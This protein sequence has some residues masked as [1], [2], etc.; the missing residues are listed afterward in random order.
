M[1]LPNSLVHIPVLKEEILEHVPPHAKKIL[2]CTVGGGGHSEALLNRFSRAQLLA[3]D[4]DPIALEIARSRLFPYHTR[5][6]L[7]HSRFSKLE[8][9]LAEISWKFDF[10]V[11]DLGVSSLQLNHPE[12]GFSFS[13]DGPLDMRMDPNSEEKDAGQWVNQTCEQELVAIFQQYGEVRFARKIGRGIVQKRKEQKFSSTQ[14]LAAFVASLIPRRFHKK[15]IH[16][17]TQVF[18]A[19]RIAVNDELQEVQAML[20]TVFPYLNARGRMAC[21]TFHSLEDRL[22]KQQFQQWENPCRCPP[23]LP[24]CV[25]GLLPLGARVVK[26]PIIP[27]KGEIENNPRSRSAKLRVFERLEEDSRE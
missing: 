3:I 14:E 4:R 16:P 24:C 15:K 20:K 7:Y 22:I 25:C 27:T 23:H 13:H 17:A 5:F 9:K 6:Q 19:L 8:E 12:R 2:D 21:I 26:R 1:S 10:I 11:A 18:Q